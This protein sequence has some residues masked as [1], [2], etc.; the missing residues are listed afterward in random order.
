VTE[1]TATSTSELLE[2]AKNVESQYKE[3]PWFRGH[4][5]KRWQLVPSAHRKDPILESQFAQQFRL[6]APAVA[7]CPDHGDYVSW[8]P[9]MRHYGLPTRL[10]DWTE[11]LLVAT[12]FATALPDLD[13]AIWVLSP[14]SLNRVTIGGFIPFMHDSRVQPLIAEAFGA[15]VGGEHSPYLAVFAPRTH[16]RMAA[17]LGNYTIHR[18][19]A[20]LEEQ[21]EVA[22]ALIRITIPRVAKPRLRRELG[23]LGIRTSSLFPDLATL[24]TEISELVVI[25]DTD[26]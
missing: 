18:L 6:R 1:L 14:G 25:E 12:Y 24:A 4:A 8:L 20:P 13:G 17:Q 21:Q 26:A 19:R 11:S 7:K 3:L 23:L 16:P 2:L 10:L 5:D 9:L 15:R 22:H